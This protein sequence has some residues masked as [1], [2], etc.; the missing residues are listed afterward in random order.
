[1]ISP[2]R[3]PKGNLSK[4]ASHVKFDIVIEYKRSIKHYL[5]EKISRKKTIEKKSKG[6][7]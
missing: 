4:I 6:K 3:L 5:H 1:V 7:E 2:L